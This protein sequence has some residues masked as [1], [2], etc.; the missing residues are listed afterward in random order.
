MS[1]SKKYFDTGVVE[2]ASGIVDECVRTVLSRVGDGYYFL[3]RAV[4]GA[5]KTEAVVRMAREGRRRKVRLAV[6]NPTN[7]QVFQ[8]I[9]RLLSGLSEEIITYTPASSVLVPDDISSHP[10]VR[11]VEARHAGS[12]G[13][14]VG[15]LR[16]LGDAFC[17][18]SLPPFDLL[19]LDEAYQADAASYFT[20]AD[21]APT[22][23][24]VGDAGQLEPF[25][26][27]PDPNLFRGL[28]HDPLQTAVGALLR[29]GTL[30]SELSTLCTYRLPGP[31]AHLA[32]HFYPGISFR[33]AVR[34]GVRELRL[35]PAK[36]ASDTSIY[37]HVLETAAAS[38]IAH[39][40]LRGPGVPDDDPEIVQSIAGLVRR[41]FDR[42]PSTRCECIHEF[43]ALNPSQAAVVVSHRRQRAA[44]R[45]ALSD[46]KLDNVF[47]ETA[48]KIQG[49]EFSAVF[50]WHSLA[51][52]STADVFHLEPGRTCVGLTRHRHACVVIG[53]EGDRDLLEGFPPITPAFPE[54]DS[55]PLLYGWDTHRQIFAGLA[56][57]RSVLQ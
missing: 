54:W 49:L 44:L 51:G 18:G 52:L 38:S 47:V 25:S 20:V 8:T 15:T 10:R 17:R 46:L 14:L 31:S 57:Y 30:S 29:H 1:V 3:L 41:F 13:L 22:H 2:A 4:A 16:K 37:D 39:L 11:I 48:N 56:P 42:A 45:A 43:T 9:R 28:P 19:I 53:R 36:G 24:L 34:D 40:E 33:H 27:A 6:A 7:E 50:Y 23:F 21:L 12:C 55:D 26:S 35:R 32:R 5:G